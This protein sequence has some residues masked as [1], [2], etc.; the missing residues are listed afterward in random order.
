[1]SRSLIGLGSNQG[2]RREILDRAVTAIAAHPD[3]DLLRRSRWHETRPVGGPPDQPAFLNGAL[4]VDTSLRPHALLEFLW[5][6]ESDFGRMRHEHWGPRT[7]DL[8]LLLFDELV[9]ETPDLV[10]PHPRMAWRRFVLEPAAEVASSMLHPTVGWTVQELL[11]HL[12]T[13][14][15]YVAIAG[16]IGAGKTRLAERLAAAGAAELIA[17]RVDADR[18]GRFYADPPSHAW[19][20]ELEFLRVRMWLLDAGLVRWSE[21]GKTWVSDFW[22][23]QSLAFARVWLAPPDFGRFEARWQE[24]RSRVVPPKLL[25]LLDVPAIELSRRVQERARPYERGLSEGQLDRIRRAVWEQV[26]QTGRGP[27]LR[28]DDPTPEKALDEVQAALAAMK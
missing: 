10:L 3:V 4:L 9:L 6:V 11:D 24:A 12:N 19:E 18:L 22:F 5:R 2:N 20:T 16:G 7:L 25:V 21:P 13:A 14:V 26:V 17:E 1:M 23:D 15:P 28:L 8:D 27:L